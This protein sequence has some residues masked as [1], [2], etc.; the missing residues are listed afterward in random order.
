MSCMRSASK[1]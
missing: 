1:R